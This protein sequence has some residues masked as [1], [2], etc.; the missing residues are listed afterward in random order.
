[1]FLTLFLLGILQRG[2]LF[3]FLKVRASFG[4]LI[5]VKLRALNRDY[6]SIGKIEEEFIVFKSASGT[7]RI[8]IKNNK[9]FYRSLGVAWIDIDDSTGAVCSPDYSAVAGFDPVKYQELYNR[10]LYKPGI[11]D[12]TTKIIIG[13]LLLI[14]VGLVIVA[15]M[16]YRQSTIIQGLINNIGSINSQ[17]DSVKG[18][19]AG[20]NV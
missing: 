16:V 8:N 14:V 2:F 13:A 15:F 4:R 17:L 1:M 10:C 9:A 18:V 7:K 20:G 6:Y 19:I 5:L 12:N 3:K 11:K